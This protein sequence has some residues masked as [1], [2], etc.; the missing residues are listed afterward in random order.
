MG[1]PDENDHS[2]RK[3]YRGFGGKLYHEVPG[4]VD[5][6]A[7][8]HV[9][10]RARGTVLTAPELAPLLMQSAMLYQ[11]RRRWHVTLW[12]LM[13]DHLHALLAFPIH[14][15]MSAVIGDWKRFQARRHGI[16]WQEGYFDHRLRD[17]RARRPSPGNG[18]LHP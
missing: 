11:E 3:I 10:I 12:L 14:E 2:G 18:G 9:R 13:P 15:S 5:P 8:F 7:L 4:W 16:V 6:G 1:L 17:R